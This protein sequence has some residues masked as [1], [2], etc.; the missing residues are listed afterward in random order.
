MLRFIW[1]VD[2]RHAA[3]YG[4]VYAIGDV[5]FCLGFAIGENC[6]FFYLTISTLIISTI[7]NIFR[8]TGPALSGTLVQ[9]I[10]FE[11][12]LFGIAIISFMYAPLLYYLRNPPT[13]EER[14]VINRL[15]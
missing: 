4:S 1:L 13:K 7:N 15:F 3:V 5:A 2:I 14:Q 12:M 11:W 10:G 9:T 6:K 8:D